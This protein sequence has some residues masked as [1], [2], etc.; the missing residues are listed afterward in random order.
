MTNTGAGVARIDGMV[1]FVSGGCDGD[2][3]EIKIIKLASGYAVG[4][5]ERLLNR[6]PHRRESD[7]AVSK[8]CGGCVYRHVS[9]EHECALKRDYVRAAFKKQ[10]LNVEVAEALTDG[11]ENGWR[12]KIAVPLSK[13][14]V[15]GYYASHTHEIIPCAGCKSHPPLFNDIIAFTQS[16][17]GGNPRGIRHLCM[18]IGSSGA[19]VCIVAEKRREYFDALAG[20]LCARFPE[21]NGVLLNINS[22]DTNVIYGENFYTLRGRDYIEDDMCGMKFRVSMPSFY[23]V[24]HG[25]AELAYTKLLQYAEIAE[26]DR[27]LDLY[28]GTGTIGLFLKKNSAAAKLTGVEI[29]PEAVENARVNAA[30]NGVEAE[31]ILGDAGKAAIEYS[32]DIIICDPPRKGLTTDAVKGIIAASPRKIA[33][34]SCD[35]DTLARDCAAL[36]AAGYTVGEV[37][38]VNM[39]PRAGHVECVCLLSGRGDK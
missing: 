20:E 8:R 4:R 26:G 32:P 27:L 9:F 38:P 23:Q 19:T 14:G 31:F 37:T 33:Y 3:A 1:V 6:S 28:C 25:A 12:D 39:F 30:L 7:C 22:G 18:R 13:E 16:R 35:P 10:G 11:L 36:S 21:I 34:M 2:T 15:F 17:L 24:N 29:V 5:V